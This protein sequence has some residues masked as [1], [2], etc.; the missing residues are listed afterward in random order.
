MNM[1]KEN[2]SLKPLFGI[3]LTRDSASRVPYPNSK[4]VRQPSPGCIF[5]TV[6]VRH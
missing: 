3:M 2:Y 4:S 5:R 6:I 1:L